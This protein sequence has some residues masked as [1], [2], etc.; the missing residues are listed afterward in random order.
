[1]ATFIGLAGAYVTMKGN[2]RIINVLMWCLLLH[3]SLA[4]GLYM[5]IVA[6]YRQTKLDSA[7]SNGL[8]DANGWR[9]PIRRAGYS[10]EADVK[11]IDNVA[12]TPEEIYTLF[13]DDVFYNNASVIMVLNYDSGTSQATEY[14]TK[15]AVRLGYPVI[16][17]DPFYPGALEVSSLVCL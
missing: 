12:P 7:I 15:S 10:M 2:L 9:S 3:V 17:W 14:I 13:C 8:R 4:A 6:P 5:Q 1:M 16:S 11:L